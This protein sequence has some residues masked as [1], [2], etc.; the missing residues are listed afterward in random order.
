MYASYTYRWPKGSAFPKVTIYNAAN[1]A[2]AWIK[3]VRARTLLSRL[4]A[5]TPLNAAIAGLL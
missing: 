5:G 3:G 4:R 2:V 1:I